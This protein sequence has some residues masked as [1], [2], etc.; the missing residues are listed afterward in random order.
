MTSPK[1]IVL[2]DR[3][4]TNMKPAPRGKREMVWDAVQP[5]L[6][7]RIT[8]KGQRSFVVVKRQA[9]DARPTRH[10][11]GTYPAIS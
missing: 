6:G 3:F 9:G 1:K 11:L 7:V 8:D 10:F 4:L 2:T 5:H